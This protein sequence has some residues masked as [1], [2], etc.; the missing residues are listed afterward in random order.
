MQYTRHRRI[1]RQ[2]LDELIRQ[3][4]R[5]SRRTGRRRIRRIL[6]VHFTVS[7]VWVTGRTFVDAKRRGSKTSWNFRSRKQKLKSVVEQ[8]PTSGANKKMQV[9]RDR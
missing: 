8:L 6:Q 1:F 5:G 3:I 7:R 9:H 4:T 2:L